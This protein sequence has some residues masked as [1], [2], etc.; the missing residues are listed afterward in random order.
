MEH[1]CVPSRYED[2]FRDFLQLLQVHFIA[3]RDLDFYADQLNITKTCLSRIVRQTGGQTVMNFI[4]QS[5]LA[6]A[7]R[8]LKTTSRSI[9]QLADDLHFAG[10]ASFTRF[11]TRLKGM[12]PRG[13]RGADNEKSLSHRMPCAENEAQ[14]AQ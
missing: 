9:A 10:Q 7:E 3:H 6:E 12:W 13:F 14:R 4:E 2:V 5:L 8:L 11:F 1:H